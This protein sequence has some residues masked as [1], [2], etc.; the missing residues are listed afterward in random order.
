MT[1][2]PISRPREFRPGDHAPATGIYRAVHVRH[3]MPH[4][5]T[6][7]EAE[8][9]PQCRKCQ[10]KVKFELLHAA[11]RLSADIDLWAGLCA[12]AIATLACLVF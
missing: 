5:L 9:F 3:R 11:P 7:L 4:E 12:V 1:A 2:L 6:V 8:I 10:E